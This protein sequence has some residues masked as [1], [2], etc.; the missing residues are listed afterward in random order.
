MLR[1]RRF[2]A[3]IA[4]LVLVGCATRPTTGPGDPPAAGRGEAVYALM[5]VPGASLVDVAGVTASSTRNAT[6]FAAGNAIDG[7]LTSAWGPAADDDA[8][9][10]TLNLGRAASVVGVGVKLSL[11][12]TSS[13]DNARVKVSVAA[14]AA[15][16][17]STTILT[18]WSPPETTPVSVPVPAT[19]TGTLVFTFDSGGADGLLVCEAHV[20]EGPAPSP[21]PTVA[22]TPTPSTSPTA[23]PSATPSPSASPSTAPALPIAA[24][25]SAPNGRTYAEWNASWWQWAWAQPDA[26]HPLSQTGA[27]DLASGQTGDVWFLGGAFAGGTYTRSGTVPVG[28]ALFFPILNRA[29]AEDRRVAT[30]ELISPF[31]GDP[32]TYP[33]TQATFEGLTTYLDDTGATTASGLGLTID[34]QTIGQDEVLRFYSIS[35]IFESP[36][37][38]GTQLAVGCAVD[39]PTELIPGAGLVNNCW[40]DDTSQLQGQASGYY[41]FVPP[42]PAGEHV[43]RFTGTRGTFTLDVTYDLTVAATP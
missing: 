35:P 15:D 6:W 33:L 7:V 20:F 4:G 22:P 38:P 29:Y 40:R 5:D 24:P 19:S 14:I 2:I 1:E 37:L 18:D 9:T 8:Q 23:P 34:G 16:G 41:V 30:G 10:L 11:G 28:T 25:D 17:T 3:L 27:V 13:P 26:T 39:D 43:I 36:L 21:S 12:G 32:L 42:L 31:P